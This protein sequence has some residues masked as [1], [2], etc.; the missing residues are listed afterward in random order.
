[1][2]KLQASAKRGISLNY[3]KAIDRARAG[4]EEYLDN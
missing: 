3:D 1:M 4:G 2:H